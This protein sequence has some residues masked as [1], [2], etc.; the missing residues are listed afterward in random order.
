MPTASSIPRVSACATAYALSMGG[1]HFCYCT[2]PGANGRLYEGFTLDIAQ[3]SIMALMGASGCGKSTLGKIM[4]RIIRPSAGRVE[5]ARQF[6]RRCDVVYIDQHPM[7]S[8]FPWQTVRHNLEYPLR[9]LGWDEDAA[10]ARLGYLTALFRL[11]GLLDALPARL[12]GGELQRLALA[13]CLSWRPELVIL[14]EPFSAL[15]GK[16]K[17]ELTI[18]LHELASKDGMT[19]VLI[20][21]NIADALAIANRCVVI[22]DRPV[23]IISDLEFKTPYPR[24]EGALDYDKMQQALISGIRDGLV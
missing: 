16:V 22:G 3:G 5:W 13:R 20:T 21:H 9:K 18:A 8:V 24:G 6:T 23:R 15:D 10:R 1:V 2:T 17:S 19:L 11:D 14:D 4:A 7:N 12:S